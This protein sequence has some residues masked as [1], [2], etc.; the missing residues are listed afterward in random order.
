[1][2]FSIL[3][4]DFI[5]V[6]V[7]LVTLVV[8]LVGFVSFPKTVCFVDFPICL[9]LSTACSFFNSVPSAGIIPATGFVPIKSSGVTPC[10]EFIFGIEVMPEG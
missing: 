10:S 4:L 3:L 5:G 9:L 8:V 2:D 7:D 1:M 6:V